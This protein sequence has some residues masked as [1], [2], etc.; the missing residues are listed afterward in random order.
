MKRVRRRPPSAKLAD[1]RLG[2]HRVDVRCSKCGRRWLLLSGTGPR[3]TGIQVG[4][5]QFQ[6]PPAAL[7]R[8][9]FIVHQVT[10][11]PDGRESAGWWNPWLGKATTEAPGVRVVSARRAL[12]A[13]ELVTSIEE[14]G[15]QTTRQR[16][17][18]LQTN[19]A[20]YRVRCHPKQ[21]GRDVPITWATLAEKYASAIAGR[22]AEIT[23]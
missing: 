17:D 23:H 10:E 9:E 14:P 12:T 4:S 3:E 5:D 21:C 13:D 15:D 19:P 16:V 6:L 11:R 22:H 18:Q 1:K 8:V 20:R 2:M 7:V